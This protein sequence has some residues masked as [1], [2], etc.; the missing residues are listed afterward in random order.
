MAFCMS[1]AITINLSWICLSLQRESGLLS[2]GKYN[3]SGDNREIGMDEG[4]KGLKRYW[5]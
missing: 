3:I 2:T 4:N 1:I 5:T